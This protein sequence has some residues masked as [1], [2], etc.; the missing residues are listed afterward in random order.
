MIH[1]TWMGLLIGFGIL[2]TGC[3][4]Q[5][6]VDQRRT[7]DNARNTYDR[8]DYRG[9]AVMLTRFEEK[10]P[11]EAPET[12]EAIYVRG[13]ANAKAGQRDAAYSDFRKCISV[14]KSNEL[15]AKA[16]SSLGQMYYE[17]R[18]WDQAVINLRAAASRMGPSPSRD[19]DA[20]MA[21]LAEAL[22]EQGRWSEARQ[23]Q[24]TIATRPPE[25]AGSASPYRND[26]AAT[27][28]RGAQHYA[29]QAG[30]F[31]SLANAERRAGELRRANFDAYI[32]QETRNRASVHVV[33][34]GRFASQDEARRRMADVKRVVP[35]AVL[36]P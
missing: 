7:Y 12:A 26:A 28:A 2:L 14:A 34:V 17:D 32:Q 6:T 30:V 25:F 8:G 31:S 19:K 9:A 15:Q 11:L 13:L 5:L 4:G 18:Q 16:Y 1:Q 36:W 3:Q 27:A 10:A 24:T 35:D 20:V 23:S 33:L 22:Q 21:R 29:V